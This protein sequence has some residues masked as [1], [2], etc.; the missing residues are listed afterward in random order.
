MT[1]GLFYHHR[2][3]IL[4]GGRAA[5]EQNERFGAGIPDCDERN[6]DGIN[7]IYMMGNY[8]SSV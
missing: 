2:I 4:V 7:T 8:K 3:I 5:A 1:D 6:L